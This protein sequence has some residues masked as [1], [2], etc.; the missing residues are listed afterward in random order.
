MKPGVTIEDHEIGG[1]MPGEVEV[2]VD[3]LVVKYRRM[4]RDASIDRDSGQIIPDMNGTEVNVEATTRAIFGA[5]PDTLVKVITMEIPARYNSDMLIPITREMGSFYTWSYGSW[6]RHENIVLAA[7]S[8]NN[9]IIWPGGDFSFNKT[10]GPRTPE[11]GY[12]PAPVIGGD[13]IGF[14]GGVCQ[15]STTLYNAAQ[16][17]ELEIIER[18][19][20]STKVPYIKAGKDATVVYGAQDLRL[21]NNFSYPVIIKSGVYRGKILVTIMGKQ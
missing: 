8:I 13:G 1:F 7:R 9:Q 16:A 21:R 15:V 10:V 19:Q 18:H 3:E 2:V 5:P 17:A 20:H 11:R 14:G 12:R 6:Q 4:P